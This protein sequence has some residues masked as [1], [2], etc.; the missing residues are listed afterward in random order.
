MYFVN[1]TVLP[2]LSILSVKT[3]SDSGGC[4]HGGRCWGCV[5][6]SS[7]NFRR[8]AWKL[9]FYVS[10]RARILAVRCN[11]IFDVCGLDYHCIITTSLTLIRGMLARMKFLLVTG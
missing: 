9:N 11:F 6:T 1:N 4:R 3:T 5:E 10:L 8:W 7:C 2:M